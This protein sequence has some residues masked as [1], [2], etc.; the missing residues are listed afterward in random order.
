MKPIDNKTVKKM[1]ANEPTKINKN[2]TAV[3]FPKEEYEWLLFDNDGSINLVLDENQKTELTNL[4]TGGQKSSTGLFSGTND[5]NKLKEILTKD[6]KNIEDLLYKPVA[7]L[8]ELLERISGKVDF[9]L[10]EDLVNNH[11]NSNLLQALINKYCINGQNL[12]KLY[13]LLLNK[14]MIPSQYKP[15]IYMNILNNNKCGLT[16]NNNVYEYINL[17]CK[18]LNNKINKKD[19]DN[20]YIIDKFNFRDKATELLY[21]LQNMNPFNNYEKIKNILD[22]NKI[23]NDNLTNLIKKLK[24]RSDLVNADN[25]NQGQV[26]VNLLNYYYPKI[27]FE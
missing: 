7:K 18:I 17:Y 14:Y 11:P 5:L 20:D 26:L 19:S 24:S 15:K 4:L 16:I 25:E 8:D 21:I 6:Y 22:G 27:S 3:K 10:I 2:S 1:M 13:N 12:D 9:T 23:K